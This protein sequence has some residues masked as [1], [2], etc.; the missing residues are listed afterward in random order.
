MSWL[1]IQ[2]LPPHHSL[3]SPLLELQSLRVHRPRPAKLSRWQYASSLVMVIGQLAAAREVAS[4]QHD[5]QRLVQ[6]AYHRA[7]VLLTTSR[8]PAAYTKRVIMM[9][10]R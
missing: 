8:V 3:S 2:C 5:L 6:S 7:W 10:A 4:D 1:R 9:P